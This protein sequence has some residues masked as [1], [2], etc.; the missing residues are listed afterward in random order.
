[1]MGRK[2]VF[3]RAENAAVQFSGIADWTINLTSSL[4]FT[5][6]FPE[7]SRCDLHFLM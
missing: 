7:E 6:L 1:M 2:R 3:E 5:L 4:E